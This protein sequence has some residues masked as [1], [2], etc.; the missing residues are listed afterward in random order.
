MQKKLNE[1]FIEIYSEQFAVKISDDFY[2][3]RSHIGGQ[4]ILSVTPSKQVNFFAVKL[5]FSKWQ[6]ESQRLE[7]PFF[8][9]DAIEVREAML[10]FMN[11]L[12][13]FIQVERKEFE[14][15]LQEA[16]RDT[17]FLILAPN[18]YLKMEIE[19]NGVTFLNEKMSK[20][21]LK[22][23][24]ISKTD[25][26]KCFQ[27]NIGADKDALLVN[28][29]IVSEVIL[30]EEI[31]KLNEVVPL[32]LAELEEEEETV[33][34]LLR[35]DNEE[36]DAPKYEEIDPVET[37]KIGLPNDQIEES[38]EEEQEESKT[39]G[40]ASGLMGGSPSGESVVTNM[41]I[42]EEDEDEDN[43]LNDKFEDPFAA[44]TIAESHEGR[45]DSLMAAISVNHRY[46]FI[47]ELFNGEAAL[48]NQVIGKIETCTSF[49]ESV[50]ILVKHYAR[51]FHWNMTS[52]EVKELLKIIFRRFR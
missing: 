1:E 22:Y 41:T 48:F 42:E 31:A 33:G 38:T 50:E 13:R 40:I 10:Q 2:A 18:V 24:K 11:V 37:I 21:I 15:L 34:D 29:S 7:S 23:V 45:A 46:M 19:R 44:Q 27:T 9:Y 32:T 51:E 16:I 12:S 47:N 8:N 43:I 4:E 52:N 6:L 20:N 36:E 28:E 25:F 17:L 30:E 49:D 14:V 3:S 35:L 26:T 39:G 5:L